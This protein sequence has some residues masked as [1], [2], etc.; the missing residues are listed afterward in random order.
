[1]IWL[2]CSWPVFSVKAI[3]AGASDIDCRTGAPGCA[4]AIE[5]V[6]IKD[7]AIT[8]TMILVTGI[9]VTGILVTGS[10]MVRA[11]LPG[12]TG[13]WPCWFRFRSRSTFDEMTEGA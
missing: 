13:R 10:S 3:W 7:A 6:A 4:M 9:L 8:G 1:M 11:V 5:A 2:A 12:G